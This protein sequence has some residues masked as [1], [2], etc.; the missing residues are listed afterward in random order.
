MATNPPHS[1]LYESLREEAAQCCPVCGFQVLATNTVSS[2]SNNSHEDLPLNACWIC[3]QAGEATDNHSSIINN[4]TYKTFMAK[5][6]QV[7]ED[8]QLAASLSVMM[9]EEEQRQEL[10]QQHYHHQQIGHFDAMQNQ[11]PPEVESRG[12]WNSTSLYPQ[13]H[14]DNIG[15]L[16]AA[17]G[18]RPDNGSPLPQSGETSAVPPDW[19]VVEEQKVMLEAVATSRRNLVASPPPTEH[20]VFKTIHNS[21]SG[22]NMAGHPM[23]L[24]PEIEPSYPTEEE[25]GPCVYIGDYNEFGQPH[26]SHGELLWDKGD[27]YVGTFHNGMR[28]EQG[29]FFFRDGT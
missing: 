6:K 1:S 23:M 2:S 26:G 15:A 10:N 12:F 27:R 28:S 7:E 16:A 14:P 20:Q 5:E 25:S 24:S 4:N 29:T 13:L 3:L 8:W 9:L 18:S 19:L 21:T 22:N 17:V 11:H